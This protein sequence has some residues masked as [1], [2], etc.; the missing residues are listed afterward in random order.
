[1]NETNC[2]TLITGMISSVHEGSSAHATF[3]LIDYIL[4]CL[5]KHKLSVQV[6]ANT[7]NQNLRYLYFPSLSTEVRVSS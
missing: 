1:M 2:I 7:L 3:F 4:S 5:F 6:Q